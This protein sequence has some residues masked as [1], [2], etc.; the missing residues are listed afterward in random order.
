MLW[1]NHLKNIWMDGSLKK[2]KNTANRQHIK[3]KKK[4]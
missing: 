3:K 4:N 2:K 1:K